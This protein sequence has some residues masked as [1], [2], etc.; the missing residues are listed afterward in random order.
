MNILKKISN[1]KING[2]LIFLIA[3]SIYFISNS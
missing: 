1:L 2:E 3:F